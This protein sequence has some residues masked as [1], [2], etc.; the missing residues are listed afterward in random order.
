MERPQPS[1]EHNANRL[2]ELEAISNEFLQVRRNQLRG[3]IGW[4]IF[5]GATMAV[6]VL[7]ITTQGS[8]DT[9]LVGRSFGLAYDALNLI[10]IN[11]TPDQ[12]TTNAQRALPFV[13]LF[14]A[15]EAIRIRQGLRN[16]RQLRG[17]I[18]RLQE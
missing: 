16:F 7:I 8:R 11:L 4:G 9:P 12:I 15:R 18:E 14:G 3:N 2:N 6:D 13:T 10:G 5:Y 1:P 17:R